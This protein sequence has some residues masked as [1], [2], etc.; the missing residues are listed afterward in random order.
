MKKVNYT[1][2]MPVLKR[3]NSLHF[4]ATAPPDSWIELAVVLSEE[5]RNVEHAEL[6][7]DRFLRAER[8]NAKGEAVT[9]LPV[10]VELR[11]FARNVLPAS[12]DGALPKPCS[13]CE[14]SGG[15]FRIAGNGAARCTCERGQRLR[16]MDAARECKSVPTQQRRIVPISRDGRA[17]ATGERTA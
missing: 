9:G 17:M 3:L 16:A 15:S 1:P 6:V 7:I 5:C 13:E 2:Y 10:P 8:S 14:I 4:A 12:A 11:N